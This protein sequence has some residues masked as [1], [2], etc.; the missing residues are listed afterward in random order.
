MF[1]LLLISLCVFATSLVRS[2][3]LVGVFEVFEGT[4][5]KRGAYSYTQGLDDG[6]TV[7]HGIDF[8]FSCESSIPQAL[9]GASTF[10][11][12]TNEMCPGVSSNCVDD[13]AHAVF[14]CCIHPSIITS[15]GPFCYYGESAIPK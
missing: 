7:A 4:C 3:G 13:G 11:S 5:S 8:V 15:E 6:C 10:D 1:A 2:S 14:S 12:K 9:V